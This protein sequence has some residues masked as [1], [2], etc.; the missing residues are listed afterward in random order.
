[1]TARQPQ[2]QH[3]MAAPDRGRLPLPPLALSV[4]SLLNHTL[5]GELLPAATL[6]AISLGVALVMIVLYALGLFYSL[7]VSDSP[8]THG[9]AES[10]APHWSLRQA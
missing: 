7:R 6:E 3:A 2:V 8:L 9:T 10:E 1:M 5:E 4:P